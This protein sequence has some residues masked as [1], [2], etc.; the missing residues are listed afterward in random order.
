MLPEMPKCQDT[1]NFN[2]ASLVDVYSAFVVLLAGMVISLAICLLERIWIKRTLVQE[3]FLRGIR[4]HRRDYSIPRASEEQSE[5]TPF[6]SSW[7]ILLPPSYLQG[8]PEEQQTNFH[9]NS[10]LLG[11]ENSS[12]LFPTQTSKIGIRGHTPRK[13]KKIVHEE[14][15]KSTLNQMQLYPFQL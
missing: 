1:S 15:S 4:V 2:S 6:E 9:F 5:S 13:R 10:S 8:I 11:K 12:I 14:D 7:S 3:Q